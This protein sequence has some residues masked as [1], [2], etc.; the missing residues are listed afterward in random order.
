MEKDLKDALS[1]S[2]VPSLADLCRQLGYSS[3]LVFRC[4][5]PLLCQEILVCRR[6][7]RN[8]QIAELRKTLQR[9]LIEE[10]AP[11]FSSVC[12]RVGLSAATLRENCPEESAAI[13]ARYVQSRSA[14]SRR[15]KEQ[16][17]EEVRH[18]V[19]RLHA[20][21]ECPSVS[22]VTALLLDTALKDWWAISA[23]VK[24]TRQELCQMHSGQQLIRRGTPD[25]L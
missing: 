20:Q 19:Q 1:D 6:N 17:R 11:S 21:S 25:R 14:A 7:L 22:R 13:C 3:S 16:L 4:H 23:S 12:R 2:P 9:V 15:R 10:P 5:F 18:I 8:Q 24:A